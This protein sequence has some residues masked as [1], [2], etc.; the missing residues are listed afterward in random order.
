MRSP[1]SLLTLDVVRGE[2]P[3][4]GRL[5]D[6]GIR[7][8]T[9]LSSLG[10]DYLRSWECFMMPLREESF[11]LLEIGVGT[12]A[13]LR[14]WREWFP[15]ARLIGLDVR[16]VF[17]D[18]PIDNCTIVHGSQTDPMV[19]RQLV[20]DYRF[21][22]I[23]DDGSQHADDKLH[24]FLAL[25]PWLE[26]DSAYLCAGIDALNG[27]A[28][29]ASGSA[30]LEPVELGGVAS[31]AWFAN[32]AVSLSTSGAPGQSRSAWQ[33]IARVQE[34]ATGVTFLR[35]SVVVTT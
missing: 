10:R 9:D 8:G 34:L 23:V 3:V 5:D 25:F 24:T 26:P 20:R 16:R 28:I 14:T 1:A 33:A 29:G 17:I 27:H 11:D 22:L 31:S 32:L 2:R 4:T 15:A 6:L 35:G 12:A 7:C 19:L 30:G 13:S 18:P 21:R